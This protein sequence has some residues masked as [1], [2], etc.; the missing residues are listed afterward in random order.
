MRRRRSLREEVIAINALL[1][2]IPAD[3]LIAIVLLIG[4]IKLWVDAAGTPE[5]AQFYPR[6]LLGCAMVLTLTLLVQAFIKAKR[7]SVRPPF[8][9]NRQV[10]VM[11]AIIF[12]HIVSIYFLGYL[13]ATII[14]GIVA[15]A[16]LGMR[17]KKILFTVPVIVALALYILFTDLLFVSLPSG[18]LL[19]FLDL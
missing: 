13:L 14:F 19:E 11:I 6:I 9:M 4:E 5:K 12:A 2:V 8:V 10:A 18:M 7:R 3:A 1:R 17:D 15:M 16:Y